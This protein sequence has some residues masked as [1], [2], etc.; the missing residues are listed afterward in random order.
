MD[1]VVSR[2]NTK[3]VVIDRLCEVGSRNRA[4]VA[5]FLVEVH[6]PWDTQER[7]G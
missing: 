2:Q 5:L 4:I 3:G 6:E 7:H 1:V